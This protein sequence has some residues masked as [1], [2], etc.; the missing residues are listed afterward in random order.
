MAVPLSNIS[1]ELADRLFTLANVGLVVG[2]VL[3]LVG[4]IGTFWTGGIRDR[5]ADERLHQA[6]VRVAEANA[7]AA[8]ANERAAQSEKDAALANL[9]SIKLRQQVSWRQISAGQ[10]NSIVAKLQGQHFVV[11]ITWI[12]SDAESGY[13]ADSIRRVLSEANI[14]V[15]QFSPSF[16]GGPQPPSG[17]NISGP[18]NTVSVLIAVFEEAGVKITRW[19]DSAGADISFVVG[20]R[21]PLPQQ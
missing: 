3:A 10:Q 7:N 11:T 12:G 21:P 16:F 13:F 15:T 14:D 6:E 8:A 20:P 1:S 17:I 5:Y 9:Q 4:T 2:A 18:E 19:P